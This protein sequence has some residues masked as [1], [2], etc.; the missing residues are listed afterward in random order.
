[1]GIVIPIGEDRDFEQMAEIQDVM[2]YMLSPIVGFYRLK[3]DFPKVTIVGHILTKNHIFEGIGACS[4]CLLPR[5]SMSINY[6]HPTSNQWPIFL[7]SQF[8]PSVNIVYTNDM[9]SYFK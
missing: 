5:L 1:M 8:V 6:Y 7:L 9:P 4:Y 2:G 3:H